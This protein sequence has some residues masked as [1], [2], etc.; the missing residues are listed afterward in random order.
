MTE[1]QNVKYLK[2]VGPRRAKLL[3]RLG[4]QSDFDLVMHFPYRYEDRMNIA[5]LNH[6]RDGETETTQGKILRLEEIRP[7]RNMNILK[8]QLEDDSG[9]AW[10][11]WF[12]QPY[13]KKQLHPGMELIV[14]GKVRRALT[15]AKTT[16]AEINVSEFEEVEDGDLLHAGRIVPVYPSTEGLTQKFWREIQRQAVERIC[17]NPTEILSLPEMEANGLCAKKTALEEIH[18]PTDYA[19]LEKARTRLVFDEFYLL[20]TA[21]AVLRKTASLGSQGVA[22]APDETLAENFVRS[23]PFALT[24]AQERVLAEVRRDMEATGPMQRLVQGDVGSGKTVIAAWAILKAIGG[25]Y[26]GVM[27]APTE[28]LARQH[29]EN[30]QKWFSPLGIRV[31]LLT[32]GMSSREKSSCLQE[33]TAGTCQVVVGTHALIQD[34]VT[35]AKAGVLVIDEQHRF[36]VRQRGL[37]EEKAAHPD[38]LVMTA[39]PIPRTLAMTIYGDLDVSVLDELPPGRKKIETVC[40]AEKARAKLQEYLRR[41]LSKGAQIFVVCPLVEESEVMDS[42]NALDLCD[43]LRTALAPYSVGLVHGRLSVAEKTAAMEDFRRGK[44]RVLV[45]TTVIEVGVDI[46]QAT[47]M[48]IEDAER[49]GIAQLHQLRGRVG[50]GGA[51][52]TCI[53]VTSSTNPRALARLKLFTQTQ[54]G[55]KLAEEDLKLRGPGEFF[56]MRQHGLP[57][58]RLADPARDT[59]VLLAAREQSL[60]IMREDPHLEQPAHTSLA[61]EVKSLIKNMVKY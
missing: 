34:T 51:Q 31:L 39:T 54:D 17:A 46:P 12:N 16:I 45:S 57:E 50:R 30:M 6:L 14:T 3:E 23:L 47:V 22:H 49:F 4:I 18:F 58:F 28:I 40:L 55:F 15:P 2:G 61:A 44:S 19:S 52:S 48:V 5:A 35:L 7:R 42:K 33:I 29:Y 8:A 43:E 53:L 25:G 60:K 32:G 38:V 36:G 24:G 1:P 59:E 11:V 20:Q 10:A 21:L 9:K 26:Q 37:L 41:E 27:M 56:G 13:L